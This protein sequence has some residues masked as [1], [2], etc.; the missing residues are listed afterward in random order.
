MSLSGKGVIYQYPADYYI[1]A[2]DWPTGWLYCGED[3]RLAAE[4]I[5]KRLAAAERMVC[6]KGVR[7]LPTWALLTGLALENYTKWLIVRQGECK[8]TKKRKKL[9]FGCGHHDLAAYFKKAGLA[10]SEDENRFLKILSSFVRWRGKYPLPMSELDNL[11]E[12][13]FPFMT[14]HKMSRTLM[15]RA[16]SAFMQELHAAIAEKKAAKSSSDPDCVS[17]EAK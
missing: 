12:C 2:R 15:R 7:L 5:W 14:Y 10:L 3:L 11:E 4:L 6:G 17:Q 16:R 9:D 8:P 1:K 13:D